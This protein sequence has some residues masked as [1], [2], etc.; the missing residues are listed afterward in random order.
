MMKMGSSLKTPA[1]FSPDQPMRAAEL[2]LEVCGAPNRSH[3]RDMLCFQELCGP[4]C[5]RCRMKTLW[6]SFLALLFFLSPTVA[7]GIS[8]KETKPKKAK[9]PQIKEEN[10]I[11][12]LKKRNFDRAL[13]ETKYLLVVFYISLSGPSQTLAEEFAK[14]ARQLKQEAPGIRFGKVDVTDQKDLKKEFNIQEFPT[15]K[16]FVDG[17]RNNPIDC[18]GVR[19]ASAF[20][21]WMRRRIGPSTVVINSTDQAEAIIN[22][23]DLAVLGFFKELHGGTVEVFYET[24]RD[25]PELPFGVTASEEVFVSYGIRENTIAVFKKGKPVH[26]EVSEDGKQNKVDL[27]RLIKT[28]TMDL[29]TEYN[30]ETSV[31]IFD[32][33]VENHILL[34]TPKNS[35]TFNKTYEDYESAAAEFRGKIMFI[36]VDTNETRNGRVFEYF[37]ITEIDV[38]AVRILNLTSDA[39]YKMPADEVTV[40]NLRSFCHSYLGGTAKPH[41]SSEEIPEDWD[42]NPVKVLVGKNFNKVAFNKTKNVFVMF[43]APWSHDCRKLFPIWDELGKK[44]ENHEN[45]VIAKI[46]FTANDIQLVMLDRYPFFRFFP[47]GSSDQAV[48]YDKEHT[49]EA[50]ADF[51][52]KQIKPKA[53]ATEKAHSQGLQMD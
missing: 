15:V 14:A 23:D 29:V 26:H 31:K 40:E 39:K 9:L 51:L 13:K 41:V 6:L 53:K 42:K 7:D 35:E 30:L 48:V 50:F 43:Y 45:I 37:R 22:S 11:L 49:L 19:E 16:F 38:P 27:T 21:T 3:S 36:L 5:S 32:V 44:Y 10:N 18:K 20:I 17:D 34:F 47:V 52:E 28:F 12:V 33:P 8:P 2:V 25:V 1:P 24:A 4:M 46:D